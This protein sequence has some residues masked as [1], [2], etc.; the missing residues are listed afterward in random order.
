M[1]TFLCIVEHRDD[2]LTAF[3][4]KFVPLL[5]GNDNEGLFLATAEENNRAIRGGGKNVTFGRYD[6]ENSLAEV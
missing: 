6:R 5:S 3:L 2:L 1:Q 4:S